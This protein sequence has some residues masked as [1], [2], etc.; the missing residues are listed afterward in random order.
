MGSDNIDGGKLTLNDSTVDRDTAA[1]GGGLDQN[2]GSTTLNATTV[3]GN[4]AEYGGGVRNEG[5]STLTL[6]ST[7]RIVENHASG[8]EH[9]GGI[10]N[11]GGSTL[12]LGGA[13]V[14]GN[15][16]ENVFES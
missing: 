3:A 14:S 7:S 2:E 16:L 5:D 15:L 13:T 11:E 4:R 9:G 12:N 1:F 8:K 6:N 10:F